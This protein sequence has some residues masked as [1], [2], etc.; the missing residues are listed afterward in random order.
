MNKNI[1]MY[2]RLKEYA[3]NLHTLSERS[4]VAY[5]T[6]YNLFTGKKAISDATS[7][8]LYK[9]ARFTGMS[10]DELYQA[11]DNH[12]D[13]SNAIFPDF[14]LMWEDEVIS[15]VKIG[16]TEV[17]AERFI[18]HPAKQIFYA[19]TVPRFIFG[20]ILK[21]RC[22]DEKRPDADKLLTALGLSEYN[23]YEICKKTHGKMLQDKTWFK[24]EGETINYS[25]LTGGIYASRYFN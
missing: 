2:E 10:M 17:H 9:L 11:L 3:L 25:K 5:S 18:L 7:D 6:V 12:S 15:S 4:G 16:E 22:F 13:E 21:D 8:T 1:L 20:Q 19:D 23:P 14:L 24:F